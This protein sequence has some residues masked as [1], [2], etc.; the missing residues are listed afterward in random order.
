VSPERAPAEAGPEGAIPPEAQSLIDEAQSLPLDER[1]RAEALLTQAVTMCN[2]VLP[3]HPGARPALQLLASMAAEDERLR[4]SLAYERALLNNLRNDPVVPADELARHAITVA[5]HAVRYRLAEVG[6]TE[7]DSTIAILDS[8]GELRTAAGA[9]L[10]SRA[11]RLRERAGGDA[12]PY[13]RRAL[14]VRTVIGGTEIEM[15]LV[16]SDLLCALVVPEIEDRLRREMAARP[17]EVGRN[18]GFGL[19]PAAPRALAEAIPLARRI[20]D[21]AGGR[22]PEILQ[23]RARSLECLGA[24]LLIQ[25]HPADAAPPLRDAARLEPRAWAEGRAATLHAI[26][27][28]EMGDGRWHREFATASGGRTSARSRADAAA[29]RARAAGTTSVMLMGVGDSPGFVH[30]SGR[31]LSYHVHYQF[32]I[33]IALLLFSWF[34]TP[35]LVPLIGIVVVSLL[36]HETGHSVVGLLRGS[37]VRVDMHGMGG[38][39]RTLD[40]VHPSVPWSIAQSAAGILVNLGLGIACRLLYNML[41]PVATYG[42]PGWVLWYGYEVNVFW[43]I[44]NAL[45]LIPLDGSH[46][47]G[48]LLRR[49]TPVAGPVLAFAVSVATFVLV[50]VWGLYN[51]NS[52]LIFI[53]IWSGIAHFQTFPEVEAAWT[54]LKLHRTAG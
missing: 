50:A 39:T 45:P 43:A 31:R 23:L 9:L 37:R 1:A 34:G 29:G 11:G 19:V 44:F 26:A 28:R 4:E 27:R 48:S 17:E 38:V 30:W 21:R 25:G 14:D 2:A 54:R 35:Y 16:E 5:D 47:V 49:I 13:F 51:H 41:S 15:A 6:V 24:V 40:P 7:V 12:V 22:S 10:L 20:L 46:V 36:A 32:L 18:T 52:F 33:L 53:L 8:R 42:W 3:L